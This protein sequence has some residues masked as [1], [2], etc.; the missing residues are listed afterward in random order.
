M[1]DKDVQVKSMSKMLEE[2]LSSVFSTGHFRRFLSFIA[3]NPNYSYRNVILILRQCPHATKTKGVRAWNKEGRWIKPGE[4]GLRINALFDKNKDKKKEEQP[5]L[6]P[7]EKKRLQ[8]DDSKFRRVSV[9]DFSQTRDADGADDS[10]PRQTAPAGNVFDI[11]RLE[12]SVPGYDALL[13]DLGE[14]APYPI[15]FRSDVKSDGSS[16]FDGIIVRKDM[17]Q[18]H[19]IRTIINLIVQAWRWI[20]CPD[21]EQ[22]EIEAESVAFIVCQ[23][24]NLDTSGFSFHHIAKYSLGRERNTPEG[25]LDYIRKTALYFIDTL[26]GIRAARKIGYADDEYFLFTNRKTAM[27]LFRQGYY[28]YLVYPGQGE[29]LAMSKKALEQYEGP[30]A[31]PRG[32]W[33]GNTGQMAA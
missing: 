3:N 6:S 32:D 25:F 28:V 12:G 8:A 13:R 19:T 20:D 7:S 1:Q 23:Y 29:L 14:A 22:R 26:D 11:A 30:F 15:Y 18:L 24:L 9:F 33:F 4:T 16:M 2:G 17:S 5:P 10:E 31:V 27:R 21:E